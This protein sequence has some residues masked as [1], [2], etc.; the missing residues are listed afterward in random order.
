MTR[1]ALF[2]ATA[3]ATLP[4]TMACER[5]D[6]AEAEAE[7]E[8]RLTLAIETPE[9]LHWGGTGVLRV[10]LANEGDTTAEGGIVEVHVP[11]WLEFGTVEP[12][13]TAVTVV[14]GDVETRLLYQLSDSMQPG[15]RRTIM[16]H[17]RVHRPP[18]AA[19]PDTG[20]VETVE[21]PPTNQVVRARLLRPSGE[22]AGIE[23]QATLQFVTAPGDTVRRR[24][25]LPPA[26]PFA[27]P[28]D[29]F[30]P[31][32]TSARTPP[33]PPPADTTPGER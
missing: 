25:T 3:V 31:G 20:A 12:P 24:D 9:A 21:L 5:R 27:P 19:P 32:D 26:R 30:P 13:G 14:G 17:L 2:L 8:P 11:E 16:Q 23:V 1:A 29:T 28:G 10:T 7:V 4:A 33:R 6:A 15:E 18:S 22:P